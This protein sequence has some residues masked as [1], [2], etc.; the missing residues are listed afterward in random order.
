MTQTSAEWL[1]TRTYA[2][3]W[4]PD[5]HNAGWHQ[6][7]ERFATKVE[8]YDYALG[9]QTRWHGVRKVRVVETHDPVTH[10]RTPTGHLSPVREG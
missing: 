8:A 1:A 4:L 2:A 3:E 10:V 5:G 6:T 7:S 9:L